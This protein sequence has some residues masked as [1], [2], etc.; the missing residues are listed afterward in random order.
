M[1][2]VKEAKAA[3]AS[4]AIDEQIQRIKNELLNAMNHHQE[5]LDSRYNAFKAVIERISG[6][7][8]RVAFEKII[9]AAANVTNTDEI[10][11]EIDSFY[12]EH[13]KN[14]PVRSKEAI[15]DGQPIDPI[16]ANVANGTRALCHQ[17]LSL[18]KAKVKTGSASQN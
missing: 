18:S 12:D 16:A 13:F 7:C 4:N 15:L 17:L 1:L 14:Y 11:L 2:Y 6:N 3:N 5:N 8:K 10:K 9:D